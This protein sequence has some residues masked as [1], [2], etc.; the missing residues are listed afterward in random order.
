VQAGFDDGC[1]GLVRR[2][3]KRRGAASIACTTLALVASASAEN[4]SGG[5]SIAAARLQGA[6]KLDGRLDEAAWAAAAAGTG[7]WQRFPD[8]GKPVAADTEF[9][10]L[11]DDDAIYVGL[12][13][14]D[15]EPAKIRGLLTRRDQDSQSDWLL[16]GFDSYHDRRTAFVFAVNP[17]GVLRDFL[18]YNDGIE[19][20]A[21]DAVW[22]AETNI[23]ELGWTAELRVP[24]SQLRF[25]GKPVEQWGVQVLRQVAR[26]GEQSVWSPWARAQASTVGRFGSLD[27]LA[28]IRPGRRL[29]LLPYVSGGVHVAPVDRADPFRGDAD[30]TGNAGLD[31]KYGLGSSFTLAATLNP[32]FGQVEADPSQVNLTANEL[33]FEEKRPFFLEGTDIFRVE[34][35]QEDSNLD[36]VFYSRRIGASPHGA[37]EAPYVDAPGTTTILGA[38]KLSGKTSRGWSVG[39]LDAVTAEESAGWND[40]ATAG[41]QVVEPL[42][43]YAVLRLKRDFRDGATALGVVATAVH[44]RLRDTG[45]E[46]SLHDQAYVAGLE[47]NHR[48][49]DLSWDLNAR[50]VGSWVHGT[51]AAI[52]GTQRNIRHLLQRPDAG[53]G[54]FDPTRQ[55]LGGGALVAD[56][57]RVGAEQSPLRFSSGID[58]RSPEF[59]ANDL[60]FHQNVGTFTHWIWVQLRN[61]EPGK[62]VLDYQVNGNAWWFTDWEPRVLGLGVDMSLLA[63]LRNRWSGGGGAAFDAARWDVAA[64]RGG[65]TLRVDPAWRG[66][67]NVDTDSRKRI[68][69]SVGINGWRRGASGTWGAGGGAGA[70]VQFRS[71]LDVFLGPMLSVTEDD[72]YVEEATDVTGTSRYVFARIRQVAAGLTLR[73]SWTHSPTLSVQFY[74]QPFIA[75]G[76]YRDYKE[77]DRP[78]AVRHQDRFHELGG[79]SQVQSDRSVLVDRDGDGGTDYSFSLADFNVRELRSNLVVRWEY[80]PGS[81]LF[82]I[83]SHG[84]ADVVEDGRFRLGHDLDALASARGEHRIMVKANYWLGL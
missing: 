84:R 75:A 40:G 35:G 53:Y 59:E 16:V 25:A 77:A 50:L 22:T 82:V 73:A 21:W 48:F 79:E 56:I 31:V 57:G 10:V 45:L 20:P 76:R 41:S 36:T 67:L 72:Q 44:R 29:E 52:A 9:R 24:L 26:S 80:R 58:L 49:L 47:F 63:M 2:L 1:Q 42:S 46:D 34:L 4:E 28:G 17:A 55:S 38:M 51:S 33:Y 64:L 19:D 61:E 6:L 18:I 68:R 11:Y 54:G 3:V 37:V 70:T 66:W 74:A 32:D 60:G 62:H 23:D 7:F 13:A 8:E 81:A 69:G 5:R 78:G 15:P 71:N 14:F 39:V 43:N 12:R 83:W 30:A 65:P 27:D